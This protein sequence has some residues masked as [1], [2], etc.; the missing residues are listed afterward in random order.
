MDYDPS[1]VSSC[2]GM[3]KSQN[4]GSYEI[5]D[6]VVKLRYSQTTLKNQNRIHAFH[7]LRYDSPLS[8]PKRGLTT[9]RSSIPPLNFLF[10]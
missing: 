9:V 3:W 2:R 1:S 10:H 8:L 4:E 7:N 5:A 6:E